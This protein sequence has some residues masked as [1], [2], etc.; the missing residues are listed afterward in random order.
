MKQEGLKHFTDMYIPALGL[1]VFFV[2]FLCVLFWVY[3]KGSSETYKKIESIPLLDTDMNQD[4][5]EQGAH[6]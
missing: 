5:T 2:I 6:T 1:F 3:R 4:Q